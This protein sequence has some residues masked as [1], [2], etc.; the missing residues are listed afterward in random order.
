MIKNDDIKSKKPK[1]RLKMLLKK[2][3]SNWAEGLSLITGETDRYKIALVRYILESLLSMLLSLFFIVMLSLFFGVLRT[4]FLIT[5]TAAALKIFMGGLHL[6]TPLRCAIAG[7]IVAVI[8][9][10]VA[11]LFPLNRF[12]LVLQLMIF[13]CL[14]I[15]IWR[16]SPLEAK[17]KPLAPKHRTC[18]AW[19]SRGIIMIVLFLCLRWPEAKGVNELFYGAIFQVINLI[20]PMAIVL[21]RL[22]SGLDRFKGLVRI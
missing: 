20:R 11:R 17:G 2:W 10:Y 16:N 9:S 13:T 1:E 4:A 14:L 22:E 6:S 15:T 7:A 3:A 12:P 18:L 5:I 21:E 8:L 19:L